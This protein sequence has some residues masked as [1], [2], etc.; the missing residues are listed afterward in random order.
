MEGLYGA[1][2]GVWGKECRGQGEGEM[3]GGGGGA[4]SAYMGI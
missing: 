4:V 2:R 3:G 1:W